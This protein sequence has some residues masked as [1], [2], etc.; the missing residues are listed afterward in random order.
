M[1]K[2]SNG[3]PHSK[4]NNHESIRFD[5]VVANKDRVEVFFESLENLKNFDFLRDRIIFMDCSDD[6]QYRKFVNYVEKLGLSKLRFYFYKRRNWNF[7]HGAQLDYIRLVG[8]GVIKKPRFTFFMQDHYLN[9][10]NFI[11]GDSLPDDQRST[12]I[13]LRSCLRIPSEYYFVQ[14]VVFGSVQVFHV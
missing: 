9:T 1:K 6:L 12:W 7:N 5:I 11:K 13:K 10:K 3:L 2:L 4:E 14:D 8:E